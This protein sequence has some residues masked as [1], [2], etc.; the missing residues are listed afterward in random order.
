MKQL[1]HSS[2]VSGISL[3]HL[4]DKAFALLGNVGLLRVGI[5]A[6]LDLGV[7]GLDITRLERRSTHGKGIGDDS[8]APDVDLERVAVGV[9]G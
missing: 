5:V 2:P 3:E 8:Q 9:Y 4:G 6:V 7:G 1:R